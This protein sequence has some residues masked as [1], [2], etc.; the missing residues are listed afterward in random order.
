M[1]TTTAI[2]MTTAVT[3]TPVNSPA[4]KAAPF[5]DEVE[6]GL[7]SSESTESSITGQLGSISKII[8]LT[9]IDGLDSTHA[10]MSLI[11]SLAMAIESGIA[12]F[13]RYTRDVFDSLQLNDGSIIPAVEN[14]HVHSL[15]TA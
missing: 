15:D 1:K 3:D 6:E 9:V 12:I 8:L 10:I 2:I 13:A 14:K 11:I 7:Q 5:I 4:D